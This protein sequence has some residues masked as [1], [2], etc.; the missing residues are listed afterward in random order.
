MPKTVLA[1][2]NPQ[3]AIDTLFRDID[4]SGAHVPVERHGTA[5]RYL[6]RCL[7]S[8]LEPQL[9][10][11]VSEALKKFVKGNSLAVT[12]VLP[13]FIENTFLGLAK[14]FALDIVNSE[15]AN[16]LVMSQAAEILVNFGRK[17]LERLPAVQGKPAIQAAEIYKKIIED[18][19]GKPG[20]N[21]GNVGGVNLLLI[22]EKEEELDEMLRGK[23]EE[24]AYLKDMFSL[25]EYDDIIHKT[26][27]DS[28][29]LEWAA[30]HL[31]KN[32]PSE[33]DPKIVT[34]VCRKRQSKTENLRPIMAALLENIKEGWYKFASDSE[35]DEFEDKT[36]DTFY[37]FG[38]IQ[39]LDAEDSLVPLLVGLPATLRPSGKPRGK[40]SDLPTRFSSSFVKGAEAGLFPNSAER[41]QT[42]QD[43]WHAARNNDESIEYYFANP[44]RFLDKIK[45]MIQDSSN[46]Q[47][48]L[49]AIQ[50]AMPTIFHSYRPE[51]LASVWD[52]VPKAAQ[53]EMLRAVG[54]NLQTNVLLTIANSG[55]VEM[56]GIAR[57]LL[58]GRQ[59]GHLVQPPRD[60]EAAGAKK[61]VT[62]AVRIDDMADALRK[63][64][65]PT[66]AIAYDAAAFI[67]SARHSMEGAAA[68]RAYL[69]S[70][71]YN[72]TVGHMIM[73][74]GRAAFGDEYSEIA[75]QILW[76]NHFD[77]T[78]RLQASEILGA[79]ARALTPD[80]EK[81]PDVQAARELK[82]YWNGISGH[83]ISLARERILSMCRN[84]QPLVESFKRILG[85]DPDIDVMANYYEHFDTPG[86]LMGDLVRN[87]PDRSDI[88]LIRQ[89]LEKN[90]KNRMHP[91]VAVEAV[92]RGY[93]DSID[94]VMKEVG[95]ND[96]T[97][98]ALA[99]DMLNTAAKNARLTE[100]SY[101]ELISKLPDEMA[102]RFLGYYTAA[103]VLNE[104]EEEMVA[105]FQERV[106]LDHA[107]EDDKANNYKKNPAKYQQE[108]N[109]LIWREGP[110][111]AKYIRMLLPSIYGGMDQ[112]NVARLW[113]QSDMEA[114]MAI[115]ESVG[116]RWPTN[117]LV[118]LANGNDAVAGA[119]AKLLAERQQA[120]LAP[121]H[122]RD[123]E[124]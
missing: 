108:I 76:A 93:A 123:P 58:S 8:S 61:N 22:Q 23:S 95:K 110:D 59:Q 106:F 71:R 6:I 114:R 88:L 103:H 111:R 15:V 82:K 4:M 69:F 73:K 79:S 41:A 35:A 80:L 83:D 66:A 91:W 21:V 11:M 49:R 17:E 12:Q 24:A 118:S 65:H 112:G 3:E 105:Q 115:L 1:Y 121:R 39:G 60:V 78:L 68:L 98:M 10:E 75:A 7:R 92:L 26:A 120:H 64:K 102:V 29:N 54:Q 94:T 27:D 56:A 53:L 14:E 42:W 32:Y 46:P 122:M 63:L 84:N 101:S 113:E 16:P 44:E 96:T 72:G 40:G 116:N 55:D 51:E 30:V 97:Y 18:G 85:M 99:S 45:A 36:V 62:A 57:S 19:F 86:W 34:E 48:Q 70:P 9:H 124:L 107:S 67:I 25:D 119:A 5:L 77:Y 13:E 31:I 74:N 20:R 87:Y 28:S 81:I 50:Q 52:S 89:L 38:G 100:R 104:A 117:A 2:N 47:I 109:S 37:F 43:Q 33:V 90:S